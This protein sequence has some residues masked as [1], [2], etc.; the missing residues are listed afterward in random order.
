MTRLSKNILMITSLLAVAAVGTYLYKVNQDDEPVRRVKTIKPVVT[1]PSQATE[2]VEPQVTK[3]TSAQPEQPTVPQEEQSKETTVLPS[4]Q[5]TTPEKPTTE[6]VVQT[7]PKHISV[8]SASTP[9]KNIDTEPEV[10]EQPEKPRD[11]QTAQREQAKTKKFKLQDDLTKKSLGYKH[12]TGWY[13][14][15]SF[16]LSFNGKEI[17]TFDGREFDRVVDSITL[18]PSKLLK[19][20]FDW[21]FLNGKRK[22]WRELEFKLNQN[23]DTIMFD[24]DWKDKES[25][26]LIDNAEVISTKSDKDNYDE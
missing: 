3:P 6:I 25:Q 18:D 5:E 2:T 17:L 21:E 15:T 10:D 24:F 4:T 23:T 9:A 1:E 7:E 8:A 13:Y 22:G 14:P 12:W 26:I 11:H 20:R 16:I 19:V